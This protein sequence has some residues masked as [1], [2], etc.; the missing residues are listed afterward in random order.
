ML[1]ADGKLSKV[2]TT[3][4]VFT[5]RNAKMTAKSN[6]IK[7]YYDIQILNPFMQKK[8]ASIGNLGFLFTAIH[9]VRNRRTD[10]MSPC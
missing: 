7:K 4:A 10:S 8:K 1:G 2:Y 3:T 9:N 5:T 6:R